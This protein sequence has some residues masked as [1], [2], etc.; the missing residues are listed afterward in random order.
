MEMPVIDVATLSDPA[1]IAAL[2]RA[3]TGTGFFYI[4][5][6]GVP[7]TPI[8]DMLRETRA[9]FALPLEQR[10]AL[11]LTRSP[12]NRGYEALKAQTLEAGTP[13]DL[14]EGFYI[15]NE[16]APDHPDVLAGFFN[17]DPN[18]WPVGQPGFRAVM[19]TY[20]V[21]LTQLA[22]RLM[23]AMALSLGLLGDQFAFAVRVPDGGVA[24]AALPAAAAQPAA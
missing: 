20:F 23:G 24:A 4:T 12:C 22:A 10:E 15:G 11:S 16:L 1:G 19:E 5:N 14:K 2:H 3:C 7:D 13:P 18:Q 21:T 9:F 6:H 8:Q 17:Q